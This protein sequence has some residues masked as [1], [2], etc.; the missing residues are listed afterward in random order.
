MG[1]DAYLVERLAEG[2][3]S[4][5]WILAGEKVYLLKGTAVGFNTGETTHLDDNGSDALQLV[6]AW[7]ELARRLPHISINET[8]LDFLFHLY[9]LLL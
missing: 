9:S 4:I 5:V 2:A 1:L 3:H 7:L 6:F 8:E